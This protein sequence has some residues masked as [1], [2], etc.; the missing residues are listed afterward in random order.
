M[1]FQ[2]KLSKILLCGSVLSSAAFFATVVQ[3]GCVDTANATQCSDGVSATGLNYPVENPLYVAGDFVLALE[4]FQVS[5]SNDAAV[6]VTG[7]GGNVS[8]NLDANSTVDGGNVGIRGANSTGDVSINALG[9]ITSGDWGIKA[10]T[11]SGDTHVVTGAGS[12]SARL[13]G[14]YAVGRNVTVEAGGDAHAQSHYGIGVEAISF[15]GNAKIQTMTGTTIESDEVGIAA[16]AADTGDVDIVSNSQV[17]ASW[18]I[19]AITYHDGHVNVQANDNVTGIG[20]LWDNGGIGIRAHSELGDAAVAIG[21]KAIISGLTYDGIFASAGTT[22]K[23]SNAGKVV[24]FSDGVKIQ[25]K[26]GNSLLNSGLI[27]NLSLLETDLAVVADLSA[28]TI[29]NAAA[30]SILG[31]ITTGASVFDDAFSNAGLWQTGG[32]SDFGGGTDAVS[33]SGMIRFGAHADVAEAATFS[34]LESLVNAGTITGLDQ[35]QADGSTSFDT[36]DVSGDY[37]GT[38]GAVLALDAFLG[39]P[40]SLADVMTVHGSTS[41]STAIQVRNT[42]GGMGEANEHGILLVDVK[43]D[44]SASDFYLANGPINAG[45]FNYD[46]SF[47]ASEGDNQFLLTSTPGTASNETV[48][49]V[50]SVQGLWQGGADAWNTH[51]GELR[52]DVTGGVQ[53]TAVADPAIPETRRNKAVWSSVRGDWTQRSSQTSFN[54]LNGANTYSAGYRQ[55]TFGVDGGADFVV[56][57][58]TDSKL[59]FGI[60]AGYQTSKLGFNDTA[61]GIDLDGGSLGAYGSYISHGVFADLLVKHD[62]LGLDYK[63]PGTGTASTRGRSLGASGN[64]GYRFGDTGS[65]IEPMVSFASTST[66]IDSFVLGGGTVMPG[67][68]RTTRVGAGARFGIT[69]E[70]YAMSLTARVWQGIGSGNKVNVSGTGLSVAVTDP[71]MSRGVFGEV[72]GNVSFNFTEASQL[73]AGGTVQFGKGVTSESLNGGLRFTW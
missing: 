19:F 18:G 58:D 24:G 3:A 28:T 51:Q 66:K 33:N 65:F 40:G 7:N 12:I 67:S 38:A 11:G 14:V 22:A 35:V 17:R 13:G 46:L 42:N 64:L 2:F 29:D 45:L 71:G 21:E 16:F 49:A 8:I 39:G 26:G 61:N 31:R 69:D 15:K 30:G 36:L 56:D 54:Y 47:K 53:I 59:M 37:V 60:V 1:A 43:V 52:D 32:T 25:S 4:N 6:S 57:V 62:W 10:E 50:D 72:T 55:H 23:I 9:M 41:G 48:V 44:A 20:Q 68:N 63:L 5:S 34:N 70:A 27:A 73:F